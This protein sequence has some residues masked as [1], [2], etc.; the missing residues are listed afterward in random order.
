M[1]GIPQEST[2]HLCLSETGVELGQLE[3]I[4]GTRL[5]AAGFLTRTRRRDGLPLYISPIFPDLR[6]GVALPIV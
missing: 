6:L 4:L 2:L 3:L 1:H 5:S